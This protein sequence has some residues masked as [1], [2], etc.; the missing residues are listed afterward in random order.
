M[1]VPFC[2]NSDDHWRGGQHL[3]LLVKLAMA[4]VVTVLIAVPGARVIGAAGVGGS[5]WAAGATAAR[6]ARA[7]SPAA[8]GTPESKGTKVFALAGKIARGGL[9]EVPMGITLREIIEEIGGGVAGGKRFKAVQ[10][11]GPSGGCLPAELADTPVSYESLA[12][13]GVI[14]DR[15]EGG[16]D[17]EVIWEE[18]PATSHIIAM[19]PSVFYRIEELVIGEYV[20]FHLPLAIVGHTYQ[21]VF[22]FHQMI[23]FQLIDLDSNFFG[24]NDYDEGCFTPLC[25]SRR[26]H[27]RKP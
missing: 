26:I 6:P 27:I 2:P 20:V 22:L 5:A 16:V 7:A 3:R 17:D 12:A 24:C 15:R 21:T 18:E 23:S 11:G 19:F 4:F 14:D 10:I 1:L 9:I 8:F 13:H 25:R